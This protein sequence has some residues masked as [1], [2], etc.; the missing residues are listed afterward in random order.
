VECRQKLIQHF[1]ITNSFYF[2]SYLREQN[3]PS[4]WYPALHRHWCCPSVL[5][6]IAS[7]WQG[8]L[9][10]HSSMSARKKRR[11][12]LRITRVSAL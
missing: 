1:L 6:Q 4:P 3:T 12:T 11:S 10:A 8:L 2:S 7:L 5:R 9:L